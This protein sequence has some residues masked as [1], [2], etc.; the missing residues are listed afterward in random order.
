MYVYLTSP[1]H[2]LGVALHIPDAA[3]DNNLFFFLSPPPLFPE[4]VLGVALHIR[5]AAGVDGFFSFFPRF[6]Q[7]M[8]SAWPYTFPMQLAIIAFFSF[9]LFPPFFPEHVLGVALHIRNAAGVDGLFSA[10]EH[11][12]GLFAAGVFFLFFL[13]CF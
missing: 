5:D 9:L 6:H 10:L 4:H 11:H 8:Y 7:S 1:E 12:L 2:V 13:P 3:G